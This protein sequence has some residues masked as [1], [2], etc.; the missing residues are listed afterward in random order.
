MKVCRLPKRESTISKTLNPNDDH[1]FCRSYLPSTCS[2][3]CA[4]TTDYT[5]NPFVGVVSRRF[6]RPCSGCGCRKPRPLYRFIQSGY[7]KYTP[8]PTIHSVPSLDR[9]N[10]PSAQFSDN[11]RIRFLEESVFAAV[12]QHFGCR[13]PVLGVGPC[14][15]DLEVVEAFGC[16]AQLFCPRSHRFMSVSICPFASDD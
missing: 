15:P 13:Q 7:R 14:D 16:S 12:C 2:C 8:A 10:T 5:G 4:W 9:P 1:E 11:T 3:E 6:E